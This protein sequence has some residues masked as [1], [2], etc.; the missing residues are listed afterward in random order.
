MRQFP[1]H[2]LPIIFLAAC[3]PQ[4]YARSI[5]GTVRDS[6][7]AVVRGAHVTVAGFGYKH[8]TET[9]GAGEFSMEGVPDGQ[10]TL[11]IESGG[12]G[13]FEKVLLAETE[14]DVVLKPVAASEEINVTANRYQTGL[15]DT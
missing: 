2:F 4:A 14:L 1:A 3:F 10:L 8:S 12:F 6:A 13:R 9:N 7:G 11:T 15:R 5:S